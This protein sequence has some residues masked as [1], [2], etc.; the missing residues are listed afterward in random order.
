MPT[1]QFLPSRRLQRVRRGTRLIDAVRRAGLPIA[2]ACGDELL[3]A[4]CGVRILEG[5]VKRESAPEREAK[6]RNRVPPQLRLA[7]AIRLQDDLI[8]TADYW[9]NES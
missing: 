7:C 9:G 8:V 3:C 6:A 2:A 5:R 4:K 1:V